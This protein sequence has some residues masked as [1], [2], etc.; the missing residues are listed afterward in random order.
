MSTSVSRIAYL[1]QEAAE[2]RSSARNCRAH[3]QVNDPELRPQYLLNIAK[4]SIQ[5]ARR[6]LNAARSLQG[7]VP[8]DFMAPSF[9]G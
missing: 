5:L 1:Q 8:I 3:A 6:A 9:S 2:Y 7:K 4:E